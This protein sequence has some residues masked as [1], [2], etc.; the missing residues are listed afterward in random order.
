M[1]VIE[2]GGS[3]ALL[4]QGEVSCAARLHVVCFTSFPSGAGANGLD[5]GKGMITKSIKKD[6][7]CETRVWR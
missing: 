3:V 7:F 1:C 5:P 6:K 2:F 4:L